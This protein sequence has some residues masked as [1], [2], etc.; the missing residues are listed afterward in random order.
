MR[1]QYMDTSWKGIKH[2]VPARN[3]GRLLVRVEVIPQNGCDIGSQ[4]VKQGTHDVV[5]YA[6]E[7]DEV[8]RLVRTDAAKA[9]FDRALR[10][11]ARKLEDL[12]R[13]LGDS[14]EHKLERQRRIAEFGESPYSI[15]AEDPAYRG[16][17]GKLMNL[18]VIEEVPPPP[19]VE[20]L[21]ATQFG[22]LG[23][24]I[25]AAVGGGALPSPEQIEARIESEV[26]RRLADIEKRLEAKFSNKGR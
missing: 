23:D 11:F 2:L 13:G 4:H 14:V 1:A 20:N 3:E 12:C 25:A 26:T 7:L 16:G 9:D 17:F 10:V 15:M 6:S 21:Q 18:T 24:V 5:I 8:K 19:T 22:K